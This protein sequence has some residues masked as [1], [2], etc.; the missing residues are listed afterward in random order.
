[1]ALM[2]RPTHT[3]IAGLAK[4]ATKQCTTA[5]IS[6]LRN[7]YAFKSLRLSLKKHKNCAL[8]ATHLKKC[9]SLA[10]LSK[11]T[12]NTCLVTSALLSTHKYVLYQDVMCKC[13]TMFSGN[14]PRQQLAGNLNR[15]HRTWAIAFTIWPPDVCTSI[16][17]PALIPWGTVT[18]IVWGSRLEVGGWR[19]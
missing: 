14:S 4:H 10:C 2:H 3:N 8:F 5:S 17:W 18:C 13:R 12:C 19:L 1:M 7:A 15:Q 11:C 16:T 9:R 6:C